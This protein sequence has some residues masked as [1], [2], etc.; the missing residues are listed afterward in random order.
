M[1]P[2]AIVLYSTARSGIFSMLVSAP[3]DVLLDEP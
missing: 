3:A 1:A 2:A